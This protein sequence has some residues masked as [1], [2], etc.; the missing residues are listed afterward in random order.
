MLVPNV[1]PAEGGHVIA[2]NAP[3]ARSYAGHLTYISYVTF[4]VLFAHE[5][6]CVEVLRA[7]ALSQC[8]PFHSPQ[9]RTV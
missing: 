9:M 1:T 7:A 6:C 2:T 3:R 4:R 8:Y 5:H